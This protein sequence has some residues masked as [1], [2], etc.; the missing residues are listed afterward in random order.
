MIVEMVTRWR[1][2]NISQIK[3]LAINTFQLENGNLDWIAQDASPAGVVKMVMENPGMQRAA[4]E[5]D[6]ADALVRTMEGQGSNNINTFFLRAWDTQGV[7]T[8]N[9]AVQ[10]GAVK[11]G[12]P[13]LISGQPSVFKRL[14]V[15]AKQNN[16]GT[17]ER[18]GLT[19]FERKPIFDEEMRNC[20][21]RKVWEEKGTFQRTSF[22]ENKETRERR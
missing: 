10:G 6:E 2:S 4:I 22:S 16:L 9:T 8:L 7:Q 14:V 1:S 21:R 13:L 12:V 19:Y 5:S 18:W 15:L 11:F 17:L 3:A 20:G